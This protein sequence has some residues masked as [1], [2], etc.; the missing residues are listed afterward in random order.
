MRKF[1][2]RLHNR[3]AFT[4][5]ECVLAV[6]IIAALS[7]IMLPLLTTGARFIARSKNL[8]SLSSLAQSMIYSYDINPDDT[9]TSNGL[10]TLNSTSQLTAMLGRNE[11]D[12]GEITLLPSD[13]SI[14]FGYSG[15][16]TPRFRFTIDTEIPDI[17]KSKSQNVMTVVAYSRDDSTLTDQQRQQRVW[18]YAIIV[19]DNS[20]E[21]KIVYYNIAPN[22]ADS[23]L[24]KDLGE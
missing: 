8:D 6:A 15:S 24:E 1:F 4:L 18:F 12:N 14:E 17:D 21:S 9:I 16:F 22:S 10:T 20:S 5:L 11:D 7:A 19:K 13:G 23:L 2:K 3:R